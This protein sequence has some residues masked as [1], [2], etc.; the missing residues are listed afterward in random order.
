VSVRPARA[1]DAAGIAAVLAQLGYPVGEATVAARLAALAGDGRSAALVA[2][3]E[4]RVAGVLTLHV[5]PVLHERGGW[6]RITA[7]VVDEAAR[8]QGAGRELVAEA[9][10]IARAAGC[11]RVEV[12]SA[13]H[14]GGAHELYRSLGFDQ[15][16][17]HFLKPLAPADG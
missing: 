4:G 9:E 1:G 14:R 3:R 5:L 10:A 2:E 16:S 8:R 6:C 17:E 13:L 11:A 15:V 7:L 12:T